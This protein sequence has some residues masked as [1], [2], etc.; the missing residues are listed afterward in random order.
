MQK[1]LKKYPEID[2]VIDDGSHMMHHMKKSFEVLYPKISYNGVYLVEDTH[3]CYWEEYGGGVERPNTFIEF[4]K[5]KI[6]ELN[7]VHS[8]NTV[9][10]T[11]LT[12]ST[13]S[14]CFYDSVIVFEKR[15]QGYR[16][17]PVTRPMR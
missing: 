5:S 15:N 13:D 12:K 17:A 8:R 3:T 9:L 11:N 4:A 16:Q 10:A 6:D 7:A 2:I 14:I 1:I